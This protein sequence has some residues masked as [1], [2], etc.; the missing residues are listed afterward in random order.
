MSI[1]YNDWSFYCLLL[2]IIKIHFVKWL[3]LGLFEDCLFMSH[4]N[5]VGCL[6]LIKKL[7]YFSLHVFTL[8]MT[9]IFASATKFAHRPQLAFYTLSLSRDHNKNRM[10]FKVRYKIM[11]FIE[12]LSGP[13]IGF[14]CGELFPLT[15]YEFTDYIL[16][17]MVSF[18]LIVKFFRKCGFIW[19]NV[20]N[21]FHYELIFF[22]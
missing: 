11:R 12:R 15:T 1:N 3:L 9:G 8:G 6:L 14:Y 17:S 13:V 10:T 16:D 4:K 2:T 5:I 22:K 7:A 21:I 19:L 18:L 20:N